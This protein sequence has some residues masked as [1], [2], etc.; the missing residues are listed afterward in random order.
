MVVLVFGAAVAESSPDSQADTTAAGELDEL[1]AIR[2]AAEAESKKEQKTDEAAEEKIFKSGNLGLQALNPEISATGDMLFEYQ[3]GFDALPTTNTTF[4][5]LGIHFEAYLDPYSRFKAAVPVTPDISKLGEAYFTRFGVLWNANLTLGRFRHQFGVVNRWHI[6]ALDWFN[7]PLA[8]RSVFGPGGLNQTGASL[9]WD[10]STGPVVHGLFLQVSDASNARMFGGN[11]DNLPSILGRYS[12]YQDL[13][14]STYLQIGLN[15]L[16]GW[17][18]KWTTV[19]TTF[20]DRKTAVVYCADLVLMWE[21]TDRMRYR[22]IEWRSEGY[23]VDKEIYAPDGS[24]ADRIKPWGFYSLLQAKLTRTVEAGIRY[25]Y[26][27][28][29]TREYAAISPELALAP[30]VVTTEDAYRHLGGVWF[31]W[32]QSPF[33]KFRCGYSYEDGEGTG[34]SAHNVT[35]QMVF[36]AGPHKHERY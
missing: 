13:T 24:G 10:G 20:N 1:E 32:W 12:Y 34:P 2:R 6:H 21:P 9:D 3:S 19:D 29:S 25:D 33:V 5:N 35:L 16:V 15:G 36:A 14:A 4:R 18:D 31:T 8:L 7:F 26:F 28:P 27:S 22:N 17:N 23:F 30:L 11:S